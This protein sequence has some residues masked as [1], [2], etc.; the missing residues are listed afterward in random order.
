VTTEDGPVETTK[1]EEDEGVV[2]FDTIAGNTYVIEI[3]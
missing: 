1:F 2:E 3:D